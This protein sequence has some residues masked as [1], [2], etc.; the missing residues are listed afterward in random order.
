MIC[1]IVKI[2][3]AIYLSVPINIIVI[4]SGISMMVM[5]VPCFTICVS[6]LPI[7]FSGMG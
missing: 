6:T 7:G 3:W 5:I 4:V 2:V 1:F